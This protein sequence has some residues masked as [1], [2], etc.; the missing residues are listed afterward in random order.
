MVFDHLEEKEAVKRAALIEINGYRFY[1]LLAGKT[2]NK[3]ARAIFKKLADDEKQHLKLI[4]THFF[5][6]AGFSDQI[7]EEELQIEDFIE[8]TG[9]A[10]IFSKR[11]NID[12]LVRAID[13]P[14][15]ALIIAL[16]TERH[17]VEYF[18]K[19][20]KRSQTEEGRKIYSELLEE[21]KSHVSQIENMLSANP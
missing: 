12:A 17:S 16:D 13:T 9:A 14:K 20:S 1:T 2:E 21:E 10:D 15:K 11:I 19:L 8:R 4:E 18:E 6:E 3:E 5:P 7:T